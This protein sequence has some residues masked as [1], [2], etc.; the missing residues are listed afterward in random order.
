MQGTSLKAPGS[1]DNLLLLNEPVLLP[2]DEPLGSLGR[3]LSAA[4]D[5]EEH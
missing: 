1:F 2:P 4:A 5:L 3:P